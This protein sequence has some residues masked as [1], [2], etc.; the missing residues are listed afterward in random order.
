MIA[1]PLNSRPDPG[2]DLVLLLPFSSRMAVVD[3][4]P[5]W[6]YWTHHRWYHL[7]YASSRHFA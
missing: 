5:G 1:D 7:W 6:H 2:P 3:R 4:L